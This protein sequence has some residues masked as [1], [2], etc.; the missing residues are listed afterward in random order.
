MEILDYAI[1]MERN[2]YE[3]YLQS[4]KK[5]N[6]PAARR[7]LEILA[8]DEKRHEEIL[9]GIQVGRPQMIE[10]QKFAGIKNIFQKLAKTKKPFINEKDCLSEV[11]RKGVDL[12]AR[13]V[14][15]YRKNAAQAPGAPEKEIWQKLQLEEEKHQKL[16]ELTLEFVDDPEVILENAEFLF[17]GHDR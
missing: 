14:E 3:F 17:Y 8:D 10:S 11:L 15:L 9:Y 6:D 13:S 2:G 7:M 1:Q 4:A 5:Q 16:L 12:E